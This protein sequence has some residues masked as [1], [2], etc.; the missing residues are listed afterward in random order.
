MLDDQVLEP[1]PLAD[2]EAV[3]AI[4][5]DGDPP[6]AAWARA[7]QP[8]PQVLYGALRA[9]VDARELGNTLA[10]AV[11]ELSGGWTQQESEQLFAL[12]AEGFAKE[13]GG[14]ALI[15]VTRP[16]TAPDAFIANELARLFDNSSNNPERERVMQIWQAAA[17]RSDGASGSSVK[18]VGG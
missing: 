16:G 7:F 8:E 5:T 1:L 18:F 17:P 14:L 9:A 12:V 6:L 15:A 2:I 3:A 13:R 11:G 4:G 10:D